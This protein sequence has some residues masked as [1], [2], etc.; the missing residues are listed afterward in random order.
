MTN[1]IKIKKEYK[2]QAGEINQWEWCKEISD[3]EMKKVK[4]FC[5]GRKCYNMFSAMVTPVRTCNKEDLKKDLFFPTVANHI[6]PDTF[7]HDNKV[8]K[9]AVKILFMVIAGIA[10]L[11][12]FPIRLFNLNSRIKANA[13]EPKENHP[14]Y[15]FLKDEKVDQK[16]LEMDR[17][18]VELEQEKT[19]IKETDFFL[20]KKTDYSL[21]TKY[22]NFIE[23]PEFPDSHIKGSH[24]SSVETAT[25]KF[26]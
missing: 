15:K 5:N 17:L 11:A 25:Q 22:V 9:T 7:P 14:L 19:Q 16:F 13:Q 18:F 6:L 12:T 20:E 23:L 10:D 3:T 21:K 24:K 1:S 26:G 4:G 2:N 8:V